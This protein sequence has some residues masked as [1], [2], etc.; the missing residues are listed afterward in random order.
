MAI[1]RLALLL[2]LLAA[3]ARRG[4][5][6]A[7]FTFTTADNKTLTGRIMDHSGLQHESIW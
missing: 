4:S 6:C 5:A 1:L 2:L 3:H 7:R